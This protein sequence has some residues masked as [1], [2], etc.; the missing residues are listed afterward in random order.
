MSNRG[1][2]ALLSFADSFTVLNGMLGI[3]AIF[4]LLSGHLR[5]A[6]SF[7]LLAVL[8]DG[9]DGTVARRY[10]SSV[11]LYMDEFADTISFCV[12]P[13][14]MVF[15][16]Y[17]ASFSVSLHNVALLFAGGL[18]VLCGMLHL[19]RY[20]LGEEP[21]FVGITTPAAALTVVAIS[22]LGLPWW[23]AVGAMVAHAVLLVSPLPY[24]RL[25][26]W[27][28]APAVAV[29]VVAAALAHHEEVVYLLLA[30]SLA[31]A[32]LGPPYVHF[33]GLQARGG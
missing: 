23:M 27:L 22:I 8:A 10:G 15:V 7:I 13:A 19:V 16:A 14:V 18:F 28:A 9:L 29:I 21:Y 1:V 11:G 25:E 33:R 2:V 30:G 26:G 17:D 5:W 6:F 3:F 24:P 12:A 31:Y 20:H 32:V 4:L